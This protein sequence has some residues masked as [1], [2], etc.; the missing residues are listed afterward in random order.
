MLYAGEELAAL[1]ER[2]VRYPTPILSVYLSVNPTHQE[3]RAKAYV[4]RLKDALKAA[5]APKELSGRVLAY[6]DAERPSVGTLALFASRDGIFDVYPLRVDLPERV[7]WGE[8]YVVPL[9]FALQQH[10][11]YGVILLDAHKA[12]VFVSVLGRMEEELDAENIFTTAGWREITISPST[13]APS[14]GAAKDAF[15]HRLEAQSLRF[16]RDLGETVRGLIERFGL[17]RLILA[18]PEERASTFVRALPRQVAEMVA[19]TVPLPLEASEKEVMQRVSGAEELARNTRQEKLLAEARE[20]GA[21]GLDETLESLQEG[22]VYHLLVP[23]PTEER[24]RWCDP[25]GL[26]FSGAKS[27]PYCGSGTRERELVDVVLEMAE[28]RGSRLEFVRGENAD[29]LREELGGLA[30]LVR[31]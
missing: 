24:V 26:A 2:V 4:V 7:R 19:A 1:K 12:R 17:A 3:N 29:M 18:G 22:R 11:P 6:V 23:W 30:G 13:A 15:E 28:A 10:E 25:C 8:P 20:R 14:G 21:S 5:G 31:F 9:I 27:C 16:Y